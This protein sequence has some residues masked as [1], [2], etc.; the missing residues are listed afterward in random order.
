MFEMLIL[1]PDDVCY[2]DNTLED[3]TE[4]IILIPGDH[5]LLF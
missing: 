1:T 2:C 4:L 5:Q 3:R